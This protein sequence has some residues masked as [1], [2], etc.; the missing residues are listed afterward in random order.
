MLAETFSDYFLNIV[1]NLGINIPGGKSGK[2]DVSHHDNHSSII[3]IKQR[4]T[5][6]KKFFLLERLLKNKFLLRLRH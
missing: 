3:T 6:I 4:T 5:D 2:G 1:S